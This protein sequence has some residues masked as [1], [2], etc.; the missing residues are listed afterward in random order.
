MSDLVTRIPR[1]TV[2]MRENQTDNVEV[3]LT[4]WLERQPQAT[5]Q[6]PLRKHDGVRF[7]FYGRMSTVEHQDRVTARRWQRDCAADL[8]AGRGVIA[9]E[10]FDAGCSRRRGWRQRPPAPANSRSALPR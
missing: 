6:P 8:V 4:Q 3:P 7:A 2:G 1:G 5:L 9:A 10:Y